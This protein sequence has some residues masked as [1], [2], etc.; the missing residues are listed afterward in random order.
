[1]LFSKASVALTLSALLRTSFLSTAA[2]A[3]MPPNENPIGHYPGN[4]AA[5]SAVELK[6][7]NIAEALQAL[8]EELR[9]DLQHSLS[10]LIIEL[11]KEGLESFIKGVSQISGH[12]SM[13]Y[14]A[15]PNRWGEILLQI[16]T[17]DKN[18]L[19][20]AMGDLIGLESLPVET[21]QF[22]DYTLYQIA[23]D[24]G[25]PELKGLKLTLAQ[26]GQFIRGSI[27]NDH[28]GLTEMLYL[29]Q[30]HPP[31]SPWRLSGQPD[32]RY[33]QQVLSPRGE[34]WTYL[35]TQHLGELLKQFMA[36]EPEL[37]KLEMEG[38]W[39]QDALHYMQG[40]GF[41]VHVDTGAQPALKLKLL[42]QHN[43][44]QLSPHQQQFIQAQQAQ[45]RY[46]F[47]PLLG[48]FPAPLTAFFA[49]HI[50]DMAQEQ[51]IPSSHETPPQWKALLEENDLST[52]QKSFF[53]YTQ[54]D[55]TKD[56]KPHLAGPFAMAWMPS[57][58]QGME[59]NN[60]L[61]LIF[62]LKP[63]T[64]LAQIL[65][66]QLKLQGKTPTP[67][68]NLVLDTNNSQIPTYKIEVSDLPLLKE[69]E[70]FLPG[71]ASSEDNSEQAMLYFTQTPETPGQPA[72]LL[73]SNHF[74]ALERMV[75]NPQSQHP[76]AQYM[77]SQHL[78]YVNAPLL[79][80][81][82]SAGLGT[83]DESLK[84]LTDYFQSFSSTEQYK[85]GGIENTWTLNTTPQAKPW[86]KLAD[87]TPLPASLFAAIA[88]PGFMGAKTRALESSTKANM[89][90]LQTIVE[91]YGVDFGGSYPADLDTLFQEAEDGDY[92]F[93]LK[94]H[95]DPSLPAALSLKDYLS[96]DDFPAGVVIYDPVETEPEES[97]VRYRIYGTDQQ[98]R[99]LTYRDGQA[100]ILTNGSDQTA[101]EQLQEHL[102]PLG[103]KP[104]TQQGSEQLNNAF[105]NLLSA[106]A[107][108]QT[109]LQKA[110]ISSTKAN[111]HTLQVLVETYGVDFG[112]N[113]PSDYVTLQAEAQKAGY[114][115]TFSNPY[116]TAQPSVLSLEDYLKEETGLAGVVIY[117]PLQTPGNESFSGYRIY[118]TNEEGRIITLAEGEP[119]M[120]EY[121]SDQPLHPEL[122]KRLVP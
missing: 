108:T 112:G 34:Q 13:A 78:F 122:V 8:P 61:G 97:I 18:T 96:R 65:A 101:P 25:T 39:V 114:S 45:Q 6:P 50:N 58:S 51:T 66:K 85:K 54:L 33:A 14:R 77:P 59:L 16:E 95:I 21:L 120:L 55:Y 47:S 36:T 19:Q 73:I 26:Q 46:D 35:R 118:G 104:L 37:Q 69:A 98:G 74:M 9:E 70:D 92:G 38:P 106:Q 11:Q 72:R 20:L 75:K 24:D 87:T 76:S 5:L 10:N 4:T 105:L 23:L 67:S 15:R 110:R 7:Q 2:L 29:S 90:T 30:V 91:T 57:K 88:L 111:M 62:D 94:N 107:P 63:N 109:S 102:K 103:E 82:L 113:Y 79:A 32:V 48:H 28:D 71:I 117:E 121:N 115:V 17:R 22:S 68:K 27:G 60:H 84:I 86:L 99:L 89:H 83:E 100:F 53:E 31:Q 40:A 116:D 49:G 52:W 12:I 81:R 42:T 3:S 119:F 56:L 80:D 1:M 93:P 44:P 43:T 41:G 64:N